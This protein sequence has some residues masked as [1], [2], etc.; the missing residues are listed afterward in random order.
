M[1]RQSM[2]NRWR[3]IATVAL[4]ASLIAGTVSPS[5]ADL[6]PGASP[7]AEVTGTPSTETVTPPAASP[8][9]SVTTKPT[10]EASATT[11]PPSKGASPE[12]SPVALTAEAEEVTVRLILSKAGQGPVLDACWEDRS[13]Y[14]YVETCDDTG[15]GS[16]GVTEVTGAPG[17][18]K[19]FLEMATDVYALIVVKFTEAPTTD[20]VLAAQQVNIQVGDRIFGI[21]VTYDYPNCCETVV[22][23]DA[24]DYDGVIPV[25]FVPGK[26]AITDV[27]PYS[28]SGTPIVIPTVPFTVSNVG[29][30][31]DVRPTATVR[32]MATSPSGAPI[33]NAN[34]VGIRQEFSTGISAWDEQDGSVDGEVTIATLPGSYTFRSSIW[35]PDDYDYNFLFDDH[36]RNLQQT[37]V[38]LA[39]E[40]NIVALTI[41]VI[42][43]DVMSPVPNMCWTLTVTNRPLEV[44]QSGQWEVCSGDLHGGMSKAT[45]V[46]P[47]G[48]YRLSGS[49]GAEPDY[50]AHGPM[51]VQV[52]LDDLEIVVGGFG[53]LEPVVKH[54]DGTPV[55]AYCLDIFQDDSGKPGSRVDVLGR[56]LCAPY[57]AVHLPTGTYWV[58]GK[59]QGSHRVSGFVKVNVTAGSAT[60]VDLVFSPTQVVFATGVLDTCVE[61]ELTSVPR[62]RSVYDMRYSACDGEDGSIDGDVRF[63]FP[64]GL[65][66][67]VVYATDGNA[68]VLG[69]DGLQFTTT[70]QSQAITARTALPTV[71]VAVTVV[72]GMGTPQPRAW[73]ALCEEVI[74]DP[75]YIESRCEGQTTLGVDSENWETDVPDGVIN[76]T[77]NPGTYWLVPYSYPIFRFLGGPP[78]RVTIPATGTY[79]TSVLLRGVDVDIIFGDQEGPCIGLGRSASVGSHL[80]ICDGPRP[81]DDLNYVETFYDGTTDGVLR[82]SL[83]PRPFYFGGHG[84]FVIKTGKT[85]VID[86]RAGRASIS[87]PTPGL[88]WR[89]A[90]DDDG[91][92]GVVVGITCLDTP[93][94]YA[95]TYWVSVVNPPAGMTFAPR[96]FTVLPNET[97]TVRLLGTGDDAVIAR[98][99]V[100]K[101][102]EGPALGACWIDEDTLDTWCDDDDGARDGVTEVPGAAYESYRLYLANESGIAGSISIRL[103]SAP[104]QNFSRVAYPLSIQIAE[105]VLG[106]WLQ[107]WDLYVPQFLDD[108]DGDGVL[109]SWWLDGRYVAS[110][111]VDEGYDGPQL[112]FGNVEVLVAGAAVS[113]DFRPLATVHLTAKKLD[114]SLLANAQWFLDGVA[115]VDWFGARDG[116]LTIVTTPG[117][118]TFGV[119]ARGDASIVSDGIYSLG[120]QTATLA[121]DSETTLDFVVPFVEVQTTLPPMG[122]C[123]YLV[124]DVPAGEFPF[125]DWLCIDE[126]D[127]VE[128]PTSLEFRVPPGSYI[129]TAS[130]FTDTDKVVIAPISVEVG[131]VQVD[132]NLTPL[133]RV[134]PTVFDADGSEVTSFCIDIWTD[135]AGEIG[136]YVGVNCGWNWMYEAI[137]LRPGSYWFAADSD[138]GL[139]TPRQSI[140]QKVT[141][142][143]NTDRFVTFDFEDSP[144]TIITGA[145]DSCVTLQDIVLGVDSFEF[146]MCDDDGDGV[147]DFELPT[148]R[149][150]IVT[151]AVPGLLGRTF[152]SSAAGVTVTVRPTRAV[153]VSV[154]DVDGNPVPYGG[155]TVGAVTNT[156]GVFWLASFIDGSQLGDEVADGV[157]E[158]RLLPGEYWFLPSYSSSDGYGGE[159]LLVTVPTTGIAAFEVVDHQVEV[160]VILAEAGN[161]AAIDINMKSGL[162]RVVCDAEDGAVDGIAHLVVEPRTYQIRELGGLWLFSAT[163]RIESGEPRTIDLR[164]GRVSISS[165][166]AGVCWRIFRDED[167]AKGAQIGLTCLSNP[168]MYPGTYWVAPLNAP[169]GSNLVDQ[170]FTITAGATTAVDVA[171]PTPT[172]TPTFTPTPTNTPTPTF[173]PTPTNTPTPTPTPT[174]TFTPTPTS[175]PTRTPTPTPTFTPTA[176][177]TLTPTATPTRTPTRVPGAL[178]VGDTVRTTGSANLR[179]NPS[180]TAGILTT[181]AAGANLTVTGGPTTASGFTWWQ[182]RTSANV[183]GWVAGNLLTLVTPTPT[184]T[185]TRTPA[186]TATRTPT[187]T[188]AAAT[189][190]RTPTRTPAAATATATRTPTR[191]PAAATATPTRTPTRTP[192]A[193]TA[194]A[195]R[196]PTATRTATRTPTVATATRTNTP[197]ATQTPTRTP[198]RTRTATV[199]P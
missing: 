160:S 62:G 167:G 125:R 26:Y 107:P 81:P 30:S 90:R 133:G 105:P 185:P 91:A 63:Y 87:S 6:A 41:L 61:L 144:A 159:P 85:N 108:D 60:A 109:T 155:L 55:D 36:Y 70:D 170:K 18:E 1:S 56:E 116:T 97:T 189:A 54:A 67:M 128:L 120:V 179:A 177:P 28:S 114:G 143:A 158:L 106:V 132:I 16:D 68:D 39:A 80:I 20:I 131:I 150:Y 5:L 119:S 45:F 75:V 117:E 7:I 195:T 156:S 19:V 94:M 57:S 138:S 174:P 111:L 40:H 21:T 165:P 198:T 78:V 135:D 121:A 42:T 12:A 140:P 73:V 118:H 194:T 134:L 151:S 100:T 24:N 59:D 176:T 190:T 181:L 163:Y 178:A 175:T 188:P 72:D 82:V 124:E 2:T 22:L 146:V 180:T 96:K 187:R 3:L 93:E 141:V 10:L 9:A 153:Q 84:W 48:Q 98:I 112:E 95:G 191:T 77:A 102:G 142:V 46:A 166:V 122:L 13:E 103:G 15:S 139:A 157:I 52:G 136:D 33:L 4:L 11:T 161:C 113:R 65:M 58:Y 147:I 137:S 34:W 99:S 172:P 184:R 123:Y 193:A 44:W 69:F 145:A 86:L 149:T 127:W 129:L 8:E 37:S 53:R 74:V 31:L 183:T 164:P 79:A 76:L 66:F 130:G 25:W 197:T 126:A 47:P 182:V 115:V 154:V 89:I 23:D 17:T 186:A 192:A 171:P 50:Y 199:A 92:P 83:E 101:A 35:P 29:F 173:T 104:V 152:T 196:T 162:H 27:S 43:I 88:C 64:P 168:E 38:T 32:L 169:A 110:M 49:I 71:D 51:V 14:P 148:G